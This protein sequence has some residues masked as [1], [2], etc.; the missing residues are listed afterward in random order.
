[1][2]IAINLTSRK[3]TPR[4]RLLGILAS[5]LATLALFA[6]GLA[7]AAA[8]AAA[9]AYGNGGYWSQTGGW[10]GSYVHNGVRV[11]CVDSE[12]LFRDVAEEGALVT[13]L[14][15]HPLD[16]STRYISGDEL[17][18]VNYAISLWGQHADDYMDAAVQA[19]VWELTNAYGRAGSYY[20]VNAPEGVVS[21][22]AYIKA[23]TEAN[24]SGVGGAGTGILSLD[25]D[26]ENEHLG[27]LTVT[28]LSPADAVGT[29]TL[30]NGVF[31]DTG[32]SVREGVTNNSSIP[33]RGVPDESGSDYRIR[34]DGVFAGEGMPQYE[35]NVVLYESAIPGWQRTVSRGVMIPGLIEFELSV[36]DVRGRI[37]TF[38]PVVGTQV[39]SKFVQIGEEFADVLTFST[40]GSAESISGA[41]RRHDDGSYAT[42][43]ARATIYGPFL[44][45]P[46][47]ADEPPPGAPIAAEDIE[48]ETSADDGPTRDYIVRSGFSPTEAGFYTWVWEIDR[49]LQNESTRPFLPPGYRFIDR[50]GQVAESSI[51]P[52]TLTVTTQVTETRAGMGVGVADA[53]TVVL[54]NGGWLSADGSQVPVVLDGTAYFT[55]LRPKLSDHAPEGTEVIA[56]LQLTMSDEGSATSEVVRMPLREGY[57]TFQWCVNEL[58]QPVEYQG[59]FKEVCD[60]YGQGSETVR[61]IPPVVVTEARPVAAVY[62]PV[63]DT[64]I[65]DGMVPDNS[66]LSFELFRGREDASAGPT[67]PAV[68]A[69]EAGNGDPVEEESAPPM[70]EAVCTD[71]TRVVTTSSV[72]VDAG[73]NQMSRYRSPVV[74]L[75]TTGTYWWIETLYHEDPD[76][77]EQTVI[78]RGECGLPNETTIVEE[79][80]VRTQAIAEVEL[81][82]KAHDLAIVEGRV[83]GV[84]SGVVTE[85]TFEVFE[86]V[87][88]EAECL[89]SN[90]VHH[91]NT[92]IVVT[93]VGE[94]YS[95]AVTF[96]KPGFYYWV[97]T[98]TYVHPDGEREIAHVGECGLPNETTRVREVLSN[99]GLSD[100]NTSIGVAALAMSVMGV[101]FLTLGLGALRSYRKRITL[102]T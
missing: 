38:E 12:V 37:S 7:V 9:A 99:T 30:A 77:G 45:Q 1:M 89:A 85:L 57:V 5:L 18:K 32:L 40:A 63:F 69:G 61:I 56:R 27:T 15:Q 68:E 73:E 23:D 94:Y 35:A 41:W 39:E 43:R 92:P 34:A 62:D 51:T 25:I 91:L 53:V 26:A 20:L 59:M 71:E 75:E 55:P 72:P 24:F 74:Q 83:P 8:P 81:G 90:R 88:A 52:S 70:E 96:E 28:E 65:V 50:F 66:W 14:E 86:K 47:E 100:A 29:V 42:V 13:A 6:G 80:R 33:V 87:G 10:M 17:K 11:F 76:T 49:E 102:L 36:S 67:D 4:R 97:E 84:E 101:G 78:H 19:Y 60:R 93:D 95:D 64:A 48:I 46:E 21:A 2:T 82:E 79:P 44:S 16:D 3:V 98:L 31:A 58:S 22:Y 54:G